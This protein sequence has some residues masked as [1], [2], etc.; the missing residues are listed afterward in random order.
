MISKNKVYAEVKKLVNGPVFKN[1]LQLIK[2]NR[3]ARIK[4]APTLTLNEP[5]TNRA[6][7][8][9]VELSQNG[10]SVKVIENNGIYDHEWGFID[11]KELQPK[12][13][14]PKST[15]KTKGRPKKATTRKKTV[16]STNRK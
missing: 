6:Y 13:K 2:T 14:T 4:S 11:L 3:Y 8:Y 10:Q 7:S 1:Y 15:P 12:P 9:R 5:N 16:K